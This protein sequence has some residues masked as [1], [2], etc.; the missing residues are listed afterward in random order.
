[1][2][3]LPS[4]QII[5][6][7]ILA[8]QSAYDGALATAAQ[9]FFHAWNLKRL[10]PAE[11]GPWDWTKPVATRGLWIGEGITQYYGNRMYFHAGF[12]DSSEFLSL[13]ARTID[14][15]ENSPATQ[16]MSAEASSMA[17]PF[18]DGALHKQRTNLAYTSLSYYLKGELIA[19]N[20]DLIIRAKTGGKRSLDD[21]MRR[22]YEE[23]YLKSPPASYY[24]KGRGY[25]AEDFTRVV[26]EV[27]GTDMSYFFTRYVRAVEPLPHDEALA[28]VGLRLIK[29]PSSLPYTAGIAVESQ[30]SGVRLGAL[31]IDSPAE[32][33]GLHQGDRLL[34]IG[35][36]SVSR[37][38]WIFM[39]NRFKQGD[40]VP[41]TVRRF[42]QTL[43]L[44]L[45]LGLP[46]IYDF[47]IQEIPNASP[48][49]RR[50]RAAWLGN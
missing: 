22:A 1:M 17:A 48:E 50:L 44:T 5:E 16:L 7:G 14:T 13:L 40:R 20:L 8:Q 19:L 29:T 10:R 23:F 12:E 47:D 27:A 6:S 11:L 31:R 18:I 33:A 28:G 37:D 41:V 4:T 49:A 3:H 39:L 30:G 45:E 36:N 25:T 26:S 32:R 46:E 15:I 24:L 34:T 42:G 21:V 2:E 38:N 43:N 35:G 9:E